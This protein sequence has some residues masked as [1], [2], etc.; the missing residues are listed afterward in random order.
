MLDCL[1][2]P[3]VR[4]PYGLHIIEDDNPVCMPYP[5]VVAMVPGLIGQSSTELFVFR[6]PDAFPGPACRSAAL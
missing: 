3:S 2:K 6:V 5:P 1:S 4:N